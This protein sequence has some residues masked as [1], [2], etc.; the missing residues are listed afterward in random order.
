M[1]TRSGFVDVG[2]G[3]YFVRERGHGRPLLLLHGFLGSSE[4]FL[5]FFRELSRTHRVLAVDLP[6]HGRTSVPCRRERFLVEPIVTD[7]RKICAEMGADS[8]VAVGYSMG[9]RIALSSAVL[10]PGWL[11]GLVLE[12]ASPGLEHV[13]Q[14]EARRLSDECLAKRLQV[15]NLASFLTEWERQPLFATQAA[16]PASA[17]RRQ[18]RVRQAQDPRGLALSLLGTG[19]GSQPSWWSSLRDVRIAT[20]LM[21]GG[22]DV[23]FIQTAKAMATALPRVRQEIVESAGHNIHLERPDRWMTLVHSFLSGLWV[24]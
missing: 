15:E 8:P 4:D 11:S 16:L 1:G 2:D 21:A 19:T 13:D 12:S 18:G 17:R 24:S 9:G 3:R 14:R 23:K 22:E 7:L 20:L 6:G 5:P 10:A